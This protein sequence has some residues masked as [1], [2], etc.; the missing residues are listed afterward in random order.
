MTAINAVN[1]CQYIIA[2]VSNFN[3]ILFYT[4]S[5]FHFRQKQLQTVAIWHSAKSNGLMLSRDVSALD[6]WAHLNFWHQVN[7]YMT[8]WARGNLTIPHG[9]T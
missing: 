1:P 7:F 8:F 6:V 3:R 2:N 9:P 5:S 4:K